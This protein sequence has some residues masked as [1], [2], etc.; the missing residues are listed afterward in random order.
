MFLSRQRVFDERHTASEVLMSRFLDYDIAL[1]HPQDDDIDGLIGQMRHKLHC[2]DR[3]CCHNTQ[4]ARV[5]TCWTHHSSDNRTFTLQC[6]VISLGIEADRHAVA[7]MLPPS[8]D[9]SS[10][11]VRAQLVG[12]LD[13]LASPCWT[14]PPKLS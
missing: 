11:A 14:T 10:I 6:L 4:A 9:T 12:W 5:G 2:L 1:Y 13:G 7:K 3:L 8:F